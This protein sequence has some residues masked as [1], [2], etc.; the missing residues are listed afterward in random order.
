MIEKPPPSTLQPPPSQVT[1]SSPSNLQPNATTPV[2]R[3][4]GTALPGEP[5]SGSEGRPWG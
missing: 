4:E 1:Q 5:I 3:L 2:I